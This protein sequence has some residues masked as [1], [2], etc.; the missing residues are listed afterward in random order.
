MQK[1]LFII[2]L[3]FVSSI[4]LGQS[5]PVGQAGTDEMLRVLQLTGKL[6]PANSFTARPFNYNKKF[7]RANFYHLIDSSENMRLADF[8]SGKYLQFSVLPLEINT[9]YN[10]HHPYGWNDEGMIKSKGFANEISAGV[11]ARV[12]PLS[13]QLQPEYVTVANPEYETTAG[14]GFNSGKKFSKFYLGQ[15]AI[16]LNF[17]PVSVAASTENLW[18]GP[19]QFSSL[20]MSNN[21]AGFEHLSLHT[22]RPLK[23]PIGSFEWQLVAGKLTEDSLGINES[24]YLKPF[25]FNK[26]EWR[27]FN[28]L[29][30]SYQPSFMKGF[31]FG[32]TRVD[33]IYNS[34]AQNRGSFLKNWLPVLTLSS[35]NQNGDP[36][37]VASNGDAYAGFF[38]RWILPKHQAEFYIEYGYNDFKQ[39]V[40]DFLANTNH[41]SA[42]IAGFKKVVTLQNNQLLDISGEVTQ[43]AQ[44]TSYIVRTAGNWYE[45]FLMNQGLTNQN[46]ILGAGS[47]MGNNVQTLQIKKIT[48]FNHLGLKLQRIQQDPKKLNGPINNIGIRD[49]QW[50]D[51]SLG[52]LGQK[53]WNKFLLKGEMQFV[54]SKNYGWENND[55]FNLYALVNMLY[56]F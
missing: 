42:F 37:Q 3:F 52:L 44:S 31:F 40:R 45:H 21:A 50:T 15:S 54:N 53:K 25:S 33:H 1:I 7:N 19:G 13:I 41:S 38:A 39:N 2:C 55:R 36:T 6:N 43:M 26:T 51:F 16:R 14:Y 46:K 29:V 28:G 56:F 4:V 17:G 48:G 24:N 47:G 49:V 34:Q 27:Y 18:W 20:L 9:R 5:I 32:V 10:S 12:G 23:T 30:L 22:N 8:T 11:Y 35:S